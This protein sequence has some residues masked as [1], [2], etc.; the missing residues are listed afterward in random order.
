MKPHRNK[1]KGNLLT[2]HLQQFYRDQLGFLTQC[3]R[4]HGDIVRLRFL[5]LPVFLLSHPDHIEYVLATNN[6]N[7]IKPKSVKLPLQKLIF[8][9][10]LL[11]SAGKDWLIRRRQ[12]QQ[13]LHRDSVSQ[14]AELISMHTERLIST[15]HSQDERDIYADMKLLTLN[16]AA[17]IFFGLDLNTENSAIPGLLDSL[18]ET[19]SSIGGPTGFIHHYLP[20]RANRRFKSNIRQINQ[21]IYDVIRQRREHGSVPNDLLST[22]LRCRQT[23]GKQLTDQQIRDEVMPLFMAG[24]EASAIALAWTFYLLTQHPEV[25]AKL[26]AELCTELHGRVP[27]ASDI[28]GL[29]YTEKVLKESMRLYPPNRSVGREALEACEIGGYRIPAKAQ[30]I[31]SQ[32]VVHRDGRYFHNP[33]Q[34]KPDRWDEEFSENLHRYAYF[35]FGGGQRVC[36]GSSIAM[37]EMALILARIVQKYE[38]TLTPGHVVEP[39]PVILL[40]PH[41]GVKVRLRQR[42]FTEDESKADSKYYHP[43]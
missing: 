42:R 20:T 15:W 27:R 38:V 33:E 40:R 21:I 14:Y 34:F 4:A 10:G 39:R 25:E 32:W 17:N 23:D 1:P 7:F 12:I 22:L 3:A 35:P 28:K 31:M 29:K 30:V 36:L 6:S 16:I 19:F 5:H 9:N 8:G 43:A 26:F 11:A 13:S 24:H 37:M 2:G 41:G 18:V